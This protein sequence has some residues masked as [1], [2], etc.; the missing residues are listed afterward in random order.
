MTSNDLLIVIE[1]GT[2][3]VLASVSPVHTGAGR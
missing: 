3:Q 2:F 1:D